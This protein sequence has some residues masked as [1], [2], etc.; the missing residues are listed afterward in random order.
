[1]G[2]SIAWIA[3]NGKPK[4]QVLAKLDLSETGIVDEA[5]E[6]PISGAELPGSWYLLFLNDFDHPFTAASALTRLSDECTVIA[7]RVEEHVM[8]SSVFSYTNGR[9]HW[10]VTHEAEQ[11]QR[12]LVENGDLP[13]PYLDIRARLFSQQD[14]ADTKSEGVDLVW[15]IPVTLAYELCGYRHDNAYLKTGEEPIFNVLVSIK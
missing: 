12:H 9:M 4:A 10:V 13:E 14:D 6:S 3:V 5:N 8:T 7:C 2:F 11:G 1:M 15:D